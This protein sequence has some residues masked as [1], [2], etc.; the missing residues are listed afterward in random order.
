[1][2][3]VTTTVT[4]LPE[5]R[6][7]VQAQVAPEEVE[8][9]VAQAAKR[10]GGSLRIPGFRAGKVPPP[11]IIQQVGREAVL[12]EAVRDSIGR[13]YAA[14]VDDAH[15]TPVGEPDLDLGDLPGR[16]EPLEFSIEIAVRP[17]ATLGDYRGIEVGRR[18]PEVDDARV[19]EE[20]DRMRERTAKTESVDRAAAQGDFVVMDFAGSVGGEAFEGGTARDQLVELG[21]GR[22]IPG[23]E[24]QLVGASAGDER[25]VSVT[26]PAD[27]GAEQLAGKD[28][29]FAVTVKDVKERRLPEVGEDFAVE[30]G[31]DTVEELRADV[32]ERLAHAEEH[33]VEQ[34]FREAVLDAVVEQATVDVPEP[35]V[36]AR[37]RELLDQML[38]QLSH[39]GI[40]REMYFRI[41]GRTEDEVLEQGKADAATA[42]R[43]EAVLAAV[44]EAEGIEPTDD[45]VLEHVGPAAQREGIK[46]KKLLDRL[47]S[48]GQLDGIRED[49][50]Q[51]RALDVLVEAASP[52]PAATAAARGKLWTPDKDAPAEAGGA[53]WTPES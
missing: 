16:G 48:S 2:A 29:E 40:S 51:R 44:A 3:S 45:E 14:A 28:A 53:L 31:F 11:V 33:Q 6:V 46:P 18:E 49:L 27:Y 10:L 38:H 24:D 25:T 5:S 9:S 35:L 37:A 8:R 7:R 19:D 43:R 36:E 47:R 34:E 26:F 52:I 22:L 4:E 32:R 17:K 23:F 15:I 30:Q 39:Q 13:W 20:L 41:S 50:A 1:M 12:D 21:S 42:L